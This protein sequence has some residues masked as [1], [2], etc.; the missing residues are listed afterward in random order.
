M[1]GRSRQPCAYRL[2]KNLKILA[3]SRTGIWPHSVFF[4]YSP[5]YAEIVRPLVHRDHVLNRRVVLQLMRGRETVPAAGA[6][7]CDLLF[8]IATDLLGR[9]IGH[10]RPC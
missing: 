3:R 5:R 7:D 10:R 2:K 8:D 4:G 6:E 9:A 1:C